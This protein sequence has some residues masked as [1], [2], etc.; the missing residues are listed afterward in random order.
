[1][2]G[3]I[4]HDQ[5]WTYSLALGP[6]SSWGPHP[7][8]LYRLIHDAVIEVLQEFGIDARLRGVADQ[9]LDHHFLCFS[10]GDAND[11]LIGNHKVLGSAQRRRRGAILQHGALFRRA[12]VYA[13]EFPGFLDLSSA[14]F[15]EALLRDT[16]IA[17]T[18]ARLEFD[19]KAG[20]LDSWEL[21]RSEE[22]LTLKV[23]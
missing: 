18:A 12:S 5:E 7:T 6:D 3:A 2:G 20:A 4:L 21:K 13:P 8:R 11:V 14:T 15:D 16:M 17:R 23:V 10:R 1:G 9:T 22:L 19:V